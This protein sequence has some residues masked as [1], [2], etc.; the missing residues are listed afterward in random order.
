[1]LLHAVDVL[2]PHGGIVH[3]HTHGQRESAQRH[4]V[5]R[6]PQRS[7]HGDAHKNGE[8]DRQGHDEG[9]APAPQKEQDHGGREARR[10]E[11]FDHDALERR[12]HEERLVGEHIH[13]E[14]RGQPGKDPGEGVAH[15]IDHVDGAGAARLEDRHQRAA[16]AVAVHDVGLHRIPIA[17]LRHV[18]HA[19][20]G[21]VD[22]ANG[23]IVQRLDG[24]GAAVE[25]YGVLAFADLRG[26]AGQ[27]QI[28]RADGVGHIGGRQPPR[29]QLHGI[30]IDIDE[31]RAPAV[32]LRHARAT[33][34]GQACADAVGAQVIELLLGQ[35]IPAQ[36]ELQHRHVGRI[37]AN[38]ERSAGPGRHDAQDG[39]RLC[40]NLRHRTFHRG[41][42]LEEHLH[43]GDAGERL[44]FDVLDAGERGGEGALE[45]CGKAPFHFFR[46]QAV[47]RPDHRDHRNVQL[48]EDIGGHAPRRQHP[49]Q[50]DQQG[51]DDERIRPA[52]GQRNNPHDG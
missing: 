23:E 8:R 13:L 39:L 48:R 32:R 5:E 36:R 10:N 29:L 26:P 6:F 38:D 21:P 41:V 24:T 43:H 28:L 46:R 47:V 12:F 27:H 16:H 52:Q 22:H 9:T 30:Q 42:G 31:P 3:Q 14:R 15:P 34:G 50:H 17:H 20:K 33:H 1:M 2:D 37:V 51:A 45:G 25:A 49:E 11:R 44:R 4:H 19:H 40:G 18:A 35:G 7:Q